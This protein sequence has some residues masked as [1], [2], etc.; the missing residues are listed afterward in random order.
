MRV[1]NNNMLQLE[2]LP[3]TCLSTYTQSSKPIFRLV[4]AA[5]CTSQYRDTFQAW[6]PRI[7]RNAYSALAHAV[8]GISNCK[9]R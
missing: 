3:I 4:Q 5:Y 6:A 7:N 2:P 1:D 8:Q 9:Q